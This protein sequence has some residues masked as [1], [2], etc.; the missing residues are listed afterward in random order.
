MRSISVPLPFL[1]LFDPT[2]SNPRIRNVAGSSIPPFG[3]LEDLRTAC[4]QT[5]SRPAL[6][7]TKH[8]TLNAT[9]AVSELRERKP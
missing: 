7:L 8:L 1:C 6:L 4:L 2:A 9:S 3:H 5:V